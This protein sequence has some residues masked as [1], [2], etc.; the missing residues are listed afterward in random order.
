[1][2]ELGEMPAGEIPPPIIFHQKT[3]RESLAEF[4]KDVDKAVSEH[5]LSP[6][7]PIKSKKFNTHLDIDLDSL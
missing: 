1:M 4:K 6:L 7:S 2:S 5:K 3:A